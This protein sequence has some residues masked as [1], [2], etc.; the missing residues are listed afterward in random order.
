MKSKMKDSFTMLI[1]IFEG[2]IFLWM[3]QIHRFCD[4]IFKDPLHVHH[5]FCRFQLCLLMISHGDGISSNIFKLNVW[6][7]LHSTNCNGQV[8]MPKKI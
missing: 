4:F 6:K 7:L 1:Q 3:S 5:K 8:P 2:R